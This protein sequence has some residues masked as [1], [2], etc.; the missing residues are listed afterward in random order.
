MTT[1]SMTTEGLAL[2]EQLASIKGLSSDPLKTATQR[3]FGRE[4]QKAAGHVQRTQFRSQHRQGQKS[5]FNRVESR[6]RNSR[7]GTLRRSI[8]GSLSEYEGIPALEV[9]IF[10]GPAL[11]YAGPQEYGTRSYNPSSP[12]KDIEPRSKKFLAIPVGDALTPAGVPRYASMRDFPQPLRVVMFKNVSRK[13]SADVVGLLVV[14]ELFD[15]FNDALGVGD[16]FDP[17]RPEYLNVVA[18]LATRTAI[19]P[20]FFLSD[21]IQDYLPQLADNLAAFLADQMEPKE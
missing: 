18:I 7:T 17:D 16:D 14:K 3:F 4:A 10:K 13:R 15:E 8:T 12:Y 6:L 9:G 19:S 2:L 21:G 5:T 20:G 11:K 1:V